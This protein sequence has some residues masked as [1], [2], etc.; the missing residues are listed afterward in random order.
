[1]AAT[2]D[3]PRNFFREGGLSQDFFSGGGG[4]QKFS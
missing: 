2:S 3:V 1:M 4:V